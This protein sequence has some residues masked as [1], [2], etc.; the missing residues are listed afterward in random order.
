MNATAI[1]EGSASSERFARLDENSGIPLVG[2]IHVGVIDRGS[3]LLQVRTSTMCNMSCTFCSTDA[4]PYSKL[5]MQNVVVDPQYL[6]QWIREVVRLK[7]GKNMEINLDS[8]G[9]PSAYPHLVE[10]LQGIQMIPEVSFVSMQT[11]GTLL[12]EEKVKAWDAAGLKRLNIS[13][14]ALDGEKAQYLF[15]NHGYN[16]ERI[17]EMVRLTRAQTKIEVNV[18]PVFLPGVNDAE[19]PKLIQF[20][21]EI[22]CKISIQKYE[23]Y[24]NSRKDPDAERVSWYHFY[25]QLEAWEKEFG[26]KLKIGPRDFN[27]IRTKKIPLVMKKGEVVFAE[28][29]GQGWFPGEM[30]GVAKDRAITVVE[31]NARVGDKIKVKIVSADNSIY[32]GKKN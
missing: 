21:K 11:N 24:K 30:I 19:M 27:I 7:N 16:I 17:K 12:T 6:L 31:C 22:G 20:A 28:I 14:H 10:L 25:R 9:E 5:H 23:F 32:L 4:G 8:V 26:V 2:L 18:T 15:G 3:N 29:K 13:I 1:E